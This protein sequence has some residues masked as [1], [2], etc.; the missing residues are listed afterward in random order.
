MI[1]LPEVYNN[2]I[3]RRRRKMPT[4]LI[5]TDLHDA[6]NE[7]NIEAVELLKENGINNFLAKDDFVFMMHQGYTFWYFK[8]DGN[9][10]PIVYGFQEGKTE[11]DNHGNFSNFIKEFL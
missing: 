11:P 8:A 4:D 7:L 6:K 5:G 10:D 9:P 2:F 3:I 1:I